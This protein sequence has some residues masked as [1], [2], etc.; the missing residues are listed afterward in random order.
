MPHCTS[1]PPLPSPQAH[2]SCSCHS[3]LQ[4]P[5]TETEAVLLQLRQGY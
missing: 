1:M 2:R 4:N 3:N 5:R